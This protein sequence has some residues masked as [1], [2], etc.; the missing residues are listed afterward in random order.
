MLLLVGSYILT[1]KLFDWRLVIARKL[2]PV[3]VL[4][5]LRNAVREQPK[6]LKKAQ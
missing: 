6:I 2:I 1:S 5:S 3:A 4:H